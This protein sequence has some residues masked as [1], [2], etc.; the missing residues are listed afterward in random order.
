MNWDEPPRED[1]QILLKQGSFDLCT[2]R[3]VVLGQEDHGDSQR[4]TLVERDSG[5]RQEPVARDGNGDADAI[6][7]FA[8]G[9]YGAAVFQAR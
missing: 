4:L 6:A 2:L 1:L 9:R 7:R 8:V 3:T 5:L